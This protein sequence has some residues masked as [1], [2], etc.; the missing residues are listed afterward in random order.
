M[1]ALIENLPSNSSTA[2]GPAVGS[3]HN[4]TSATHHHLQSGDGTLVVRQLPLEQVLADAELQAR[5][6][7]LLHRAEN[8]YAILHPEHV[9]TEWKFWSYRPDSSMWQPR[10]IFQEHHGPGQHGKVHHGQWESLAVLLPRQITARRLTHLPLPVQLQGW[11][12]VGGQILRTSTNTACFEPASSSTRAIFSAIKQHVDQSRGD[13]LQ[14]EDLDVDDPL[15]GAVQSLSGTGFEVHVPY[16]DRARWRIDLRGGSAGYWSKFSSK[17]RNGFKRKQ[18]KCPSRQ[19]ECITHPQDVPRFLEAASEISKHTWQTHELG[20]RIKNDPRDQ[21]I[22]GALAEA[23]LFRS[24]LW[25][26]DG[27]PVAFLVGNQAAETFHYEEVGFHEDFADYSPGLLMLIDVLNDMLVV[28]TPRWFDFGGGDAEYKRIFGNDQSSS[29]TTWLVR[30][31]GLASGIFHT[32]LAVNLIR[33]QGAR[34]RD[35]CKERKRLQKNNLQKDVP[36]GLNLP[37]G[38]ENPS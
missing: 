10:V 17:T 33:Q 6:V 28:N 24:Y 15:Y 9:A 34:L 25:S 11:H 19:L 7:D 21:A 27:R 3:P 13:F 8:G 4:I 22:Y 36:P 14:I 32:A 18:K 38:D 1:P 26:I 37:T 16:G 12:L 31:H 35:Y 29:G 23:G 5:W 20:L 30:R 2:T